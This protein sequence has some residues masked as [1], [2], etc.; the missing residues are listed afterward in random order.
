[1]SIKNRISSIC[2]VTFLLILCVIPHAFAAKSGAFTYELKG[3]GNA[4]ITNYDWNQNK[5]EDIY[6][7][8][9]IDG[10]IV[11]EVGEKAFGSK[12]GVQK[13]KAV[14]VVLPDTITVIGE[15][16]FFC[17]N[18]TACAIPANVQYIGVAAFAG[19]PNMKYHSVDSGNETFATI[20]DVLYNKSTKSLI[21]WPLGKEWTPEFV[22][23]NGITAIGDYAF[24]GAKFAF[25]FFE[26]CSYSFPNS[27]KEIGNHAFENC[28]MDG[29]MDRHLFSCGNV[30][31]IG[32]RAFAGMEL[33]VNF[34]CT[35]A[36]EVGAY[37]FSNMKAS[38]VDNFRFP[39]K[40]ETIGDYAFYKAF[41]GD[42]TSLTE[43]KSISFGE[44]LKQIGV[45]CFESIEG[46]ISTIDFSNTSL[47]E[48]PERAFYESIDYPDAYHSD[49]VLEIKLPDTVKI[50]GSQ[51]FSRLAI[52][53]GYISCVIINAPQN[54]E[55]I[56]T[57]AFEYTYTN[58]D[59]SH[60]S[61][62]KAIEE[63]AFYQGFFNESEAFKLPEGLE[64]IGN[65]AFLDS[66][67]ISILVIPA[68]VTE[69][70]KD[71][72]DR[73]SVKLSV[74]NGTYGALY[75]SENGY[76]KASSGGDDT[77]WLNS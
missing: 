18:I 49:E 10:Y 58:I 63:K 69:I 5:G 44:S 77:S 26:K 70:G 19:C 54:L 36:K 40:A 53:D 47:T 67:G 21:S 28:V 12:D 56:G 17:T 33:Q 7:P 61:S 42:S 9:M 64:S 24:Y 3:N 25:P 6:V 1:M 71:I 22:I 27:L 23:P 43:Y 8:R 29:S 55:T 68:S 37:A 32:E 60:L 20:E 50:I 41:F 30:E 35:E 73:S 74:T 52:G 57:R 34:Y 59:L 76:S 75:A 46:P 45:S 62:L 13:G 16:A 51:A 65:K 2:F 11:T 72:C 31:K 48:I 4:V 38:S 14:V 66:K 15:N 39:Y